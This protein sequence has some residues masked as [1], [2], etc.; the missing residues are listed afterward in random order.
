MS[1][2]KHSKR[3]FTALS[4]LKR[5]KLQF[6]KSSMYQRDITN[7]EIVERVKKYNP[8]MKRYVTK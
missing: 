8:F 3:F 4:E 2:T 6:P 7:E 5:I 1:K